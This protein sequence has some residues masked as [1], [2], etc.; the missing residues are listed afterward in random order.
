MSQETNNY[1][2]PVDYEV[3]LTICV[4]STGLLFV[5]VLDYKLVPLHNPC[6]SLPAVCYITSMR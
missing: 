3:M 5:V 6:Q 4:S 2:H 1:Y